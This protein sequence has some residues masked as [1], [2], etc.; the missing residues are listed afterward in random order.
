MAV[1]NRKWAEYIVKLYNST[2]GGGSINEREAA[3]AKLLKE[4]ELKKLSWHELETL[5]IECKAIV[6]RADAGSKPVKPSGDVVQQIEELF[7]VY[8]D[9]QPHERLVVALWVLHTGIFQHFTE[10]PRLLFLSAVEGEG[11]T[12]ALNILHKLIDPSIKCAGI[13]AAAL[14]NIANLHNHPTLLLDEGRNLDNNRLMKAVMNS[15]H[16]W[17]GG[18]HIASPGGFNIYYST[19]MPMAITSIGVGTFTP[20]FLSRCIMIRLKRSRRKL[21]KFRADDTKYDSKFD[22]VR[23]WVSWARHN[24]DLFN[25]D[26]DLPKLHNRP[27]DNWRPLIAI[28]DALKIGEKARRAMSNFDHKYLVDPRTLL[29][30]DLEAVFGNRSAMHSKEIVTELHRIEASP[31]A[32]WR[33][34]R[35]DSPARPITV[36]GLADL[37]RPFEPPIRPH[38]IEIARVSAKG[39][40][41]RDFTEHWARYGDADKEPEQRENADVLL[42]PMGSGRSGRR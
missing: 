8:L 3:R 4:L 15:G 20:E 37:L 31:W 27:A 34:E 14:R 22:S 41:R 28:A 25:V 39:Y 29:L 7:E 19:F 33:G 6:K 5:I 10:S 23:Q 21:P 12:T 2:L 18:T 30:V 16:E 13:T 32:E 11:K 35:G 24:L 1:H 17:D 36:Y 26:P 38:T 42:F 40:Y 9:L